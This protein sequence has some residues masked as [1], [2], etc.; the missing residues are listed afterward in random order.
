M[1]TQSQ[2]AEI[3]LIVCGVPVSEGSAQWYAVATVAKHE[4]AIA[5]QFQQRSIEYYLPLYNALRRWNERK[6]WLQLPLFSGY[7][8]VHITP[9]GKGMVERVPGVI[10][11]VSFSGNLVPITAQEMDLLRRVVEI[12]NAEPCP[13]L[14]KGKRVRVL[15]GPLEGVEGIVSHRKGKFRIVISVDSIMRSFTAEVDST[16]V[17]L[18]PIRESQRNGVAHP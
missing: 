1:L 12:W 17:Q 18:E 9:L 10:R 5:K 4:K 8:F 14:T 15:S 7:I 16:A 11:M 13:Y 2:P 3:P 6:V